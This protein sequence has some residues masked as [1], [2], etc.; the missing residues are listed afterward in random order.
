MESIGGYS[1]IAI[2]IGLATLVLDK[3]F[4][5]GMRIRSWTINSTCCTMK[6]DTVDEKED[7]VLEKPKPVALTEVGTNIV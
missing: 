6:V 1:A 5:W 4:K 3:L 2:G 7:V